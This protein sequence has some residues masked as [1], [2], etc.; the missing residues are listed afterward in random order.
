MYLSWL[1]LTDIRCYETLRFEPDEGVNV[2]VGANGAGKTSI[3]E[4]IAYLGLLKSFRGTPDVA[5]INTGS[6][7]AVIRGEFTIPSGT[8]RVEVELSNPGRRRVLVNGKRPQR[9]RDVMAQ[10]PI[11]AF[12]PDDLD[13]VKRGPGLRRAYLDDLAAQLWPQAGADQQDYERA[14]RQRNSLLKQEGRGADPITLDVWDERVSVAGA[15]V[16]DHRVRVL[17]ALDA[18]LGEAYRLVG[19]TGS[20]TWNYETNWGASVHEGG[21]PERLREELFDRRRRDMDQRVTSGGPHRD[22]PSLVVDGRPAR[23]MA[24]QGEQRTVA[25]A[26][27]VAAYRVLSTHRPTTPILLL[28]DVF[29]E[30]DPSH[31]RGVMSLF[32]AGQVLV[33]TAREDEAPATGRRWNVDGRTVT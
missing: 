28:D 31:A 11:V 13:L 16:F 14:V 6:E 8:T 4:A 30:L 25:L 33:T 22:E 1:E 5:M 2:L 27:R 24:S 19:E 21:G 32:D 17:D 3:L 12:Q 26:L 15:A 18:S 9:N 29:S 7:R 20:L 23:T 10:I